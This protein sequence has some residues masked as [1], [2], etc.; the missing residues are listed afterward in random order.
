SAPLFDRSRYTRI[1]C[2]EVALP[3]DNRATLFRITF[4]AATETLVSDLAEITRS[5]RQGQ[6]AEETDR[7]ATLRRAFHFDRLEFWHVREVEV[8]RRSVLA[9]YAPASWTVT[10]EPGKKRTLL[11]VTM[12]QEPLTRFRLAAEPAN[13]QRRVRVLVPP[14]PG[15]GLGADWRVLADTEISR[16][17]LQ[18]YR[19]DR[20]WVELPE[21]AARDYRLEIWNE[22]NPPLRITGVT[23]SGPARRLLFEA[24]AGERYWLWFGDPRAAAP[25]Y[26]FAAVLARLRDH[27]VAAP[28]A[29]GAAGPV[30]PNPDRPPAA[31]WERLPKRALLWAGVVLMVAGLGWGMWRAAARVGKLAE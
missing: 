1:A 12:G 4:D 17:S 8:A 13:H 16:V 18:G 6:V 3:A 25:R 28:L 15:A 19:E 22:D 31:F 9:E 2:R 27:G 7:T 14:F 11:R 26:D 21:T 20:D 10:E 29:V 24:R 30:E 5:R 23:A